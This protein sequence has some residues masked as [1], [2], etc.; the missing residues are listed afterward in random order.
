MVRQHHM[1]IWLLANVEHKHTCELY[2]DMAANGDCCHAGPCCVLKPQ[3]N[4]DSQQ[5][6]PSMP[7]N[8][9]KLLMFTLL[10]TLLHL[11]GS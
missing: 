4:C 8:V 11:S 3:L 10:P 6:T 7:Y 9:N 1:F 2:T 5:T